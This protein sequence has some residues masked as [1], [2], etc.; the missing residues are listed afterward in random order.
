MPSV[1]PRQRRFFGAELGRKRK[2][3]ATKT[4]LSAEK[5]ADFASAVKEPKVKA[6]SPMKPPKPKAPKPPQ[7][8]NFAMAGKKPSLTG[9]Y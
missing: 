7:F 8:G 5:L 4:G 2:G 1:T 9:G 6:N 3:L